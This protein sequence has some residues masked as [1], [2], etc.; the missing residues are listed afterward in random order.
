MKLFEALLGYACVF[1]FFSFCNWFFNTKNYGHN[2]KNQLPN[3]FKNTNTLANRNFL[4][5]FYQFNLNIAHIYYL[6]VSSYDGNFR[7][8]KMSQDLSIKSLENS[9]LNDDEYLFFNSFSNSLF[10]NVLSNIIGGYSENE[11]KIYKFSKRVFEKILVLKKVGAITDESFDKY[12]DVIDTVYEIN[13]NEN[14]FSFLN[15]Y[16]YY[17]KYLESEIYN[18]V[19]SNEFVEGEAV[20][21]K[22]NIYYAFKYKKIDIDN[23]LLFSYDKGR[24]TSDKITNYL[25]RKDSKIL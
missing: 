15:F 18:Y 17:S 7:T 23:K 6:K 10:C 2:N 22:Q 25:N 14:Y 9:G 4:D 20:K 19:L 12:L 8:S 1:A 24:N 5:L 11:P 13:E 16:K 21:V 3:F